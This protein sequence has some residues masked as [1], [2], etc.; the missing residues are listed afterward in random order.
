MKLNPFRKESSEDVADI[1][2]TPFLS[3][4][5]VLIPVLLVSVKFTVLAQYDIHSNLASSTVAT[6]QSSTSSSFYRL[7]ISERQL[8][9]HYDGK[10]LFSETLNVEKNWREQ[11]QKM[12]DVLTDKAPLVIELKASHSYQ[13]MIDLLDVVNQ[14]DQVF[15][16]VSVD[17]EDHL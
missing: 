9:L 11:L 15:S 2:I 3:L 16:S 4:M 13:L 17:V 7:S 1:D 5:V 10:P 8:V 6:E 12:L 14:K